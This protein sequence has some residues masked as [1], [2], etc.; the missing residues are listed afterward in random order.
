MG[1][2]S[3]I[4]TVSGHRRRNLFHN[5][6]DRPIAY[7]TPRDLEVEVGKV[8]ERVRVEGRDAL[9]ATKSVPLIL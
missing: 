5:L 6:D 2:P 1:D 9:K 4:T 3:K 8:R 7:V